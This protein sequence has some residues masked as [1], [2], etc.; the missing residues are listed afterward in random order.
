MIVDALAVAAVFSK[1]LGLVVLI[2]LF[3]IMKSI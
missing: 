3:K 1:W 2:I